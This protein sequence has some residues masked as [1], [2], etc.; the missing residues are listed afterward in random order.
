MATKTAALLALD[1]ACYAD[2]SCVHAM[3]AQAAGRTANKL[4]SGF[5]RPLLHKSWPI[6][7]MADT[8]SA[9]QGYRF[10]VLGGWRPIT[11]VMPVHIAPRTKAATLR[12]RCQIEDVGGAGTTKIAFWVGLGSTRPPEDTSNADVLW[13]TTAAGAFSWYPALTA[14]HTF[15]VSA[16]N[17]TLRVWA[18]YGAAIAINDAGGNSTGTITGGDASTVEA[19]ARNFTTLDGQPVDTRQRYAYDDAYIRLRDAATNPLSAWM[20]IT[21]KSA[22]A[23]AVYIEGSF[24][25]SATT[26]TTYQL[27]RGARV[28]MQ[29]LS[30]YEAALTSTQRDD[31]GG[32]VPDE[33]VYAQARYGEYVLRHM[34]EINESC[35]TNRKHNLIFAPFIL[36]ESPD[37]VISP[38]VVTTGEWPVTFSR[39]GG[40][41]R[42]RVLVAVESM[43]NSSAKVTVHTETMAGARGADSSETMNVRAAPSTEAQVLRVADARDAVL[44]EVLHEPDIN[45]A[46]ASTYNQIVTVSVET[47]DTV[48]PFLI[49]RGVYAWEV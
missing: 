9:N 4:L 30:I 48:N 19:T 14:E 23:Q 3:T 11:P 1:E 44:V 25:R 28:H 5:G 43:Q 46:D 34:H 29:T 38:A 15:P 26:A 32:G 45:E 40:E 33:W 6:H 27:A 20:R 36:P 35:R 22:I 37:W 39:R 47:G 41:S 31:G 7:D 49:V 42:L 17:A 12:V 2:G 18:Y 21:S 8:Y 24:G 10:N 16:S 13:C